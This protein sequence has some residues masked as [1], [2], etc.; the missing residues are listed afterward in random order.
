MA[1]PYNTR[2]VLVELINL[3]DNLNVTVDDVEFGTPVRVT[4][5]NPPRNTR[6]QITS[7]TVSGFYGVKTINYNRMHISEI[8]TIQVQRG[9]ANNHIA[10]LP[11]INTKYGLFLTAE[12]IVDQVIPVGQT[13]LITVPLEISANS[14][15][16]YGGA[17]IVTSWP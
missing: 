17:I 3:N 10:L 9:A 14:L 1:D 15:S 8:G 2:E 11:A 4:D 13:G 7:K 16:F 12:D 6:L 5:P